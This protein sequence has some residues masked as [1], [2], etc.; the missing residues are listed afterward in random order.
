MHSPYMPRVALALGPFMLVTR[1]AY[2]RVGGHAARHGEIVDDVGLSRAIKM[3]GG[4][5]RLANGT[6]VARTRWYPDVRGMWN[7]FSK[8]A[9]GALDSNQLLATLTCFALVPLLLAPFVRLPVGLLTDGVPGEVWFQVALF[10]LGRFVSAIVGRD[11]IWSIPFHPVAVTFWG[12]TLFRSAWL[13]RRGS[14]VVWRGREVP[15]NSP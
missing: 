13:S 6:S 8:N 2:D 11:P 14:S 3:S 7:G 5:V 15:V 9:F 1:D 4:R 10:L 12:A